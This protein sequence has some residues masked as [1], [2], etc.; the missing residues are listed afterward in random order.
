MVHPDADRLVVVGQGYTG[1]P[2]AIRAVEVGFHVIGFDLDEARVKRL[3]AGDS[4]VEDITAD[5]LSGALGTGRYEPTDEPA[6][7]HGFDVA[8][9]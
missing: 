8:V 4:F 5:M 2:V 1:L 3:A 7:T 9:I 6:R